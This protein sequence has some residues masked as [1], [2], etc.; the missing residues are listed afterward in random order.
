MIL[1]LCKTDEQKWQETLTIAQE[2]LQQRINLWDGIVANITTKRQF[3]P[4]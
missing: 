1:E 2:A 4:A 3:V